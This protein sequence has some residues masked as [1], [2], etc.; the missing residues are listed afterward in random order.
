M[1]RFYYGAD[2]A[3]DCLG[4]THR[5]IHGDNMMNVGEVCDRNQ[6]IYGCRQAR[7]M[8]PMFM[9]SFDNKLICGKRGG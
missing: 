4:I 8:P 6:T 2:V 5:Y 9:H 1:D 7:P 3:C